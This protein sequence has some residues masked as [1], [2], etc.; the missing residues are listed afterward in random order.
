MLTLTNLTGVLVPVRFPSKRGK[1]SIRHHF[2]G[3][4]SLRLHSAE[5]NLATLRNCI[6]DFQKINL[7]KGEQLSRWDW[8][9]KLSVSIRYTDY[10]V[11]RSQ[12]IVLASIR[13]SLQPAPYGL[14]RFKPPLWRSDQNVSWL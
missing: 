8:L 9:E 10:P 12:S 13:A 5:I 1:N 7:A 6:V 3:V 11:A 2:R 14:T 4:V